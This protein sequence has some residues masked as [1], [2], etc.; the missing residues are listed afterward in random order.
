MHEFIYKFIRVDKTRTF[1][2]I[3]VMWFAVK[4]ETFRSGCVSKSAGSMIGRETWCKN[5]ALHV[6]GQRMGG[7]VEISIL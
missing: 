6:R 7:F 2:H 5:E 4:I 1:L 3:H